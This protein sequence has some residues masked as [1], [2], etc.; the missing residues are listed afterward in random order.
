LLMAKNFGTFFGLEL[1][2]KGFLGA[3]LTVTPPPKT[4]V[5]IRYHKKPVPFPVK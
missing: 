1:P 5:W 4:K 2:R 3:A